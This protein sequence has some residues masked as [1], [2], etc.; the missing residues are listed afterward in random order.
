MV[1][2]KHLFKKCMVG[3]P[4]KLVI[5]LTVCGNNT[6]TLPFMVTLV[7]TLTFLVTLTF[8]V[9]LMV[10]QTRQRLWYH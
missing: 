2:T 1:T 8:T 7:V 4:L 6:V 5:S 3:S 10:T 9:M